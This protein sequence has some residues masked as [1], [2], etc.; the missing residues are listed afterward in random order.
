VVKARSL[1]RWLHVRWGQ[2]KPPDVGIEVEQTSGVSAAV[3]PTRFAAAAPG[4]TCQQSQREA[5]HRKSPPEDRRF[6]LNSSGGFRNAGVCAAGG[7][8]KKQ[9]LSRVNNDRGKFRHPF[10]LHHTMHTLLL[11]WD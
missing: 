3:P 2:Q 11:N 9:P 5:L 1:S 6:Q 7:L 4:V 8:Q 10:V